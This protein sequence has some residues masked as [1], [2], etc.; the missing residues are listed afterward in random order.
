M[1]RPK[2]TCIKED[3]HELKALI[4]KEVNADIKDRLK[5]LYFY[6]L[7]Y[8]VQDIADRLLIDRSSLFRWLKCY[9]KHGL[10]RYLNEKTTRGP[11]FT[12]P[13]DLKGELIKAWKANEF[14]SVAKASIWV[15]QRNPEISYSVTKNFLLQNC[16]IQ[17]R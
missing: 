6:K 3:L 12:F 17:H 11:K 7:G 8:S 10:D 16:E 1:G 4:R 15:Q 9:K 5:L 14:T 2:T 13:D